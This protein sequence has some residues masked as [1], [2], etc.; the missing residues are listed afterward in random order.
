MRLADI[1]DDLQF[2]D[3]FDFAI[4]HSPSGPSSAPSFLPSRLALLEFST[5]SR[6][7]YVAEIP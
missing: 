5:S 4:L 3:H 1:L 7:V 2:L 6:F